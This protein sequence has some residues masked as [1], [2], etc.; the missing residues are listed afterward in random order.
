MVKL[1]PPEKLE[2]A[3]LRLRLPSLE[4]AEAIFKQYAQDPEVTRYMIW[5]PHQQIAVTR[6]FLQRCLRCWE[7]GS[8]FPWVITRKQDQSLLGMIELRL[9]GFKAD[10]GYGLARQYWGQ[11]YATEAV[12]ALV[13][14]ALAQEG[15]YRVWAVCDTEN[16]ASARVLEK[17][18]LERE[19][20]LRRFVIHPALSPEPRDCYCY[21]IVK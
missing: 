15:I 6:E 14:W 3:R 16:L 18:G 5:R 11:G 1:R 8:A 12:Q 10:L 4:D 19:G 20:V 21:A 2:T 9:V 17:A 13:G 7:E